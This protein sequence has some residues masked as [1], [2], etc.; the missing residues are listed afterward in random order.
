[1]QAF[2]LRLDP[3]LAKKL[4]RICKQKGYS[5]TGLVKSLI[6]DFV[7]KETPTAPPEKTPPREGEKRGL[8]AL[9]GIVSWGGDSVKDKR[10]Y[11]YF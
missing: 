8:A 2:T 3:P 7:E 4:D 10:E 11:A 9:A 1:M 5:K 6:R